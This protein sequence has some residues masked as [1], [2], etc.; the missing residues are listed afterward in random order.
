MGR[1]GTAVAVRDT[2]GTIRRLDNSGS[3]TTIG[4]TSD[5][6]DLEDTNFNLIAI[7]FSAATD[8][9]EINHFQNEGATNIPLIFGDILLGSGDDTLTASAGIINGDVDFGG[10]NDTLSLSGGLS[11]IHI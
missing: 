9:I 1:E 11:L 10:G 8:D 7:D 5:P 6:L 2:S 4:N 3:I